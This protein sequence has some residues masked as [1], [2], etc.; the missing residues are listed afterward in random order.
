MNNKEFLERKFNEVAK[1]I[2]SNSKVLDI[3]C[4]NG[5]LNDFLKEC[6]Y[7][8]IDIDKELINELTKKGVKV[9]QIDLNKQEIPF[10]KEKFDYIIMLDVLEHI[11][12]PQ[13]LLLESK[14]RLKENGKLIITLPND[15]HILNKLRFV[16]N[17][18]LTEDPF[19]PYGH[20]HYFSIKDGENFLKTNGFN[21]IRKIPIAPVKPAIVSQSIKNFLSRNFQQ[22]FARD[23]L[24]LIE[25]V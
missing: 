8:G 20:L 5:K 22:A 4:N 13:K 3:G 15:Y 6:E 11:I 2:P 1:F 16:F 12:N 17:K 7:Y 9:K 21:I 25:P 23:V 19:A 18:P 24:Y 14:K 10:K